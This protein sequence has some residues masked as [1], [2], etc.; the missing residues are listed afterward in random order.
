MKAI[1]SPCFIKVTHTHLPYGHVTYEK[2]VYYINVNDIIII[3]DK[4]LCV[5][6]PQCELHID[7]TAEEVMSLIQNEMGD[8]SNASKEG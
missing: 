6:K 7:Q 3:K 4:Y 5:S 1:N 2:S 8:K